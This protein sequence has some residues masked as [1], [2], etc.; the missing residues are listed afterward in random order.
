MTT[1]ATLRLAARRDE[2]LTATIPLRDAALCLDDACGLVFHLR[3]GRCPGCG[4]GCFALIVAWLDRQVP[5]S[6]AV[7][8]PRVEGREFH[9]GARGANP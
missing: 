5:R 4:S 9:G 3:A 2:D 6:P 7:P 8:S 1:T